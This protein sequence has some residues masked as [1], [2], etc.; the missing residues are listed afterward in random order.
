[1]IERYVEQKR[2]LRK[3]ALDNG[4]PNLPTENEWTLLTGF[5]GLLKP[6]K[7]LTR[8]FSS[9][10]TSLSSVK[11][12]IFILTQCIKDMPAPGLGS[13][14]DALLRSL[15]LRFGLNTSELHSLPTLLDP[16]YKTVFFNTEA[17][18]ALARSHL[19]TK[20]NEI[21]ATR[22]VQIEITTSDPSHG[23]LQ[24]S[25]NRILLARSAEQTGISNASDDRFDA[26][27]ATSTPRSR[28][29]VAE[30][31]ME[32]AHYLTEPLLPRDQDVL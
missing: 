22:K 28:S 12:E 8:L 9:R 3:Y 10:S 29:Q 23:S 30:A 21:P 32:V 13:T 25:Y 16:R 7:E 4:R 18:V 31:E 6:F 1:M 20:A 11:P 14:K 17:A 26:D 24:A 27:A 2:V 5:L 15:E 19:L